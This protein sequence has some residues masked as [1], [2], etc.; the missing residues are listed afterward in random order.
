MSKIPAI[1]VFFPA[2]NEEKNI[3]KSVLQALVILPQVAQEFEIIVIDDGSIDKTAAIVK[4]IANKKPAVKLI[5][6][7]TNLGYGA[8]LKTGFYSSRYPLICFTDSDGQFDFS[9]IKFFLPHLKRSDLIVGYRRKR[10][11]GLMREINA[12]AWAFLIR[13]LFGLKVKDLDCAFKVIKKRVIDKIPKLESEG[14]MISAEL[15]VKTKKMGFK[16]AEIPVSHYPRK[17]GIQTGANLKVIAKA[18]L[19]L[20]RLY[21]KLRKIHA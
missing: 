14:A 21:P 1:S 6:H 10:A 5:S 13:I 4:R 7:K 2:H 19:D 15:L 11:E 18:F 9:E 8:S 3:Q 16:I 12:K 20:F 17:A